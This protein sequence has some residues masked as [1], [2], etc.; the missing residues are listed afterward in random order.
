MNGIPLDNPDLGWVFRPRS[1]PYSAL[2]A[3]SDE[4]RVAGRDGYVATPVTLSAPLMPL[5]VNTPP[6]GWEAL[7]A[8][9]T[10]RQLVLTRD[11]EPDVQVSARLKGAGPDHVFARN[12][13]IDA[14]F[15]VEL[16]EV[17]WRG[18]TVT[19][20]S[21]PL[22]A[23]SITLEVFAGLS[24]SVGDA[25]V[26]VQ[27]PATGVRVT[28]ASGAW[29]AMPDTTAGQWVRFDSR[30]GRCFRTTADAWSGGTDVSGL[31]DFGG[32]R[33][34]FEVT[35]VLAPGN[36]ASRTGRLTVTSAT[37]AGAVI[38]VRGRSARTI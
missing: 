9:F 15:I 8:L 33:G 21:A 32:P 16:T 2:E 17:Y 28:D 30:T 1:M 23:A 29:V 11:D 27:G 4:L 38:A 20:E 24:G 5:V 6:S 22:D 37:R 3:S 18:K 19:T 35:P 10:A 25:L 36:P 13:W 7:L 34:N 14:T 12:E 31:V 26:R